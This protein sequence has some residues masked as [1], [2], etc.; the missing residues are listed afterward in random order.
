M[1][2]DQMS[3]K[4][5]ASYLAAAA[6]SATLLVLDK[7]PEIAAIPAFLVWMMINRKQPAG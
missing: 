4:H 3:W 6:I 5:V 1:E 7:P 2:S